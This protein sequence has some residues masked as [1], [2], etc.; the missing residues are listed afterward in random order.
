MSE[1][2]LSSIHDY[3]LV[4]ARRKHLSAAATSLDKLL[5]SAVDGGAERLDLLPEVDGGGGAL[6]DALGGKLEFL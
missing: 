2:F 3:I 6:G 5:E 1:S 4:V